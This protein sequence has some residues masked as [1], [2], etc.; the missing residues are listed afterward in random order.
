MSSGEETAPGAAPSPEYTGLFAGTPPRT[1]GYEGEIRAEKLLLGS[2]VCVKLS[3]HGARRLISTLEPGALLVAGNAC[4]ILGDGLQILQRIT[5]HHADG[6]HE[7]GAAAVN[8]GN[9]L[10]SLEGIAELVLHHAHNAMGVLGTPSGVANDVLVAQ[11]AHVVLFHEEVLLGGQRSADTAGQ[12]SHGLILMVDVVTSQTTAGVGQDLIGNLLAGGE[13]LAAVSGAL[14]GSKY[15][16]SGLD[17]IA[18]LVT[19][20]RLLCNVVDLG[21]QSSLGSNDLG[22]SGLTAGVGVTMINERTSEPGNQRN[23]K[24]R[25]SPGRS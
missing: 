23:G 21:Y 16:L 9:S 2:S 11:L 25:R 18:Q 1:G 14:A 8:A 12:V 17:D 19:D 15:Q 24:H 4:Q 5:L 22:Y 6:L 7:G 10:S 3:Q 13:L 20:V